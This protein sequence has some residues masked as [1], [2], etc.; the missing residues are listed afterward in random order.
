MA[1]PE[2][3]SGLGRRWRRWNRSRMSRWKKIGT[4]AES[5]LGLLGRVRVS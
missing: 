1:S 3:E 4:G 5:Q 2:P